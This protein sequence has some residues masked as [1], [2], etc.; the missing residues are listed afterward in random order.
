MK[1]ASAWNKT[2]ACT[3][4][5]SWDASWTSKF[6]GADV[7]HVGDLALWCR[8]CGVVYDV[9]LGEF[10]PEVRM[11]PDEVNWADRREWYHVSGDR[12][13]QD[14]PSDAYVHV[15]RREVSEWLEK[16]RIG[17]DDEIK[18]PVLYK[19]R[20]TGQIPKRLIKDKGDIWGSRSVAYVQL[21]EVPGSVCLYLP[22][23]RLD[24]VERIEL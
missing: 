15:G 4:C 21:F 1:V 7:E 19:V 3:E 23:S 5:G 10:E 6:A 16:V 13:W 11:S 14:C 9:L 22:K 8:I 2:I 18:N 24:L 17:T 20:V 12:W